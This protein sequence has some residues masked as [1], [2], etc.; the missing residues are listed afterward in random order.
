MHAVQC[1]PD[2]CCFSV[3]VF[4]FLLF[5]HPLQQPAE[6]RLQSLLISA[7]FL[8]DSAVIWTFFYGRG[9]SNE[10]P[11]VFTNPQL[12]RV[13]D[14]AERQLWLNVTEAESCCGWS[15]RLTITAAVSPSL[16]WRRGEE[17]VCLLVC[18]HLCLMGRLND[19]VAFGWLFFLLSAR[20]HVLLVPSRS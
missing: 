10:P 18:V 15:G 7:R 16:R 14:S 12:T 9:G 2:D 3:A 11:H 4:V 19:K 1:A 6:Y 20:R 13:L 5:F 17:R 8:V